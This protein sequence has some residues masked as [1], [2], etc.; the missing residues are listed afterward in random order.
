MEELV[1]EVG[2]IDQLEVDQ[3][4]QSPEE[5]Q[6]DCRVVYCNQHQM[7]CNLGV[8]EGAQDFLQGT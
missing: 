7:Q 6:R 1:V 8:S 2:K 4:H 3:V 5:D